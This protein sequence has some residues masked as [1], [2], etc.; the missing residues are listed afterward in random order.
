MLINDA[1]TQARWWMQLKDEWKDAQEER[2]APSSNPLEAH[3]ACAG[4]A[5]RKQTMSDLLD[6]WKPNFAG[7]PPRPR[8][9]EAALEAVRVSALGRE[10]LGLRAAEDAR[11]R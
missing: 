10:G 11:R 6:S 5:E 4:G 7:P 9:D 2:R 1:D 8:A 3:D